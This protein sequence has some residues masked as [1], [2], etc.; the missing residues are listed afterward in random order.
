[1]LS[2]T[3]H[4]PRPGRPRSTTRFT[5][6]TGL[7]SGVIFFFLFVI[8]FSQIISILLSFSRASWKSD[9]QTLLIT[10]PRTHGSYP[11]SFTRDVLP[12]PIHSH[13]DY[14]RQVPLFS[15]IASGCISVEADVWEFSGNEL[16]VGHDS[17]SLTRNRTFKSLYV[18]PLV[19][20]LKGQNP[21]TEFTKEMPEGRINGVYDVDPGQ[22]LHLFVDFKTPGLS[23]LPVVL[24]HLE[25]L[26]SPVNYLTHYNGSDIVTGPVT[27]HFTGDAPFHEMVTR[28]ATYRDYFY[29]APLGKLADSDM[30]NWTNSLIASA[31]F[32]REVGMVLWGRGISDSQKGKVR[33]QVGAA[34]ERG[35]M[36]RYWD[37][38]G[39]PVSVRDAVWGV[40]MGEGVDLL[41]ADDLKAAA[42]LNW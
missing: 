17:S 42:T 32:G 27:V 40:L 5:R 3:S 38:P 30:Y 15:A 13:N 28:N 11:T 8:T 2:G 14:W 34:H 10:W 9:I 25:P 22:T 1:M 33:E 7:A 23:T 41:N 20:I 12:R 19:K 6:F 36:A 18:E 37:T 29:D 21:E 35:I 26:R 16:F 31:P 24:S 4:L 39:W